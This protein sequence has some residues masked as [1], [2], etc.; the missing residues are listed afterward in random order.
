MQACRVKRS[1]AGMVPDASVR[2]SYAS[3]SILFRP[4]KSFTL[5]AEGIVVGRPGHDEVLAYHDIDFVH[6]YQVHA[7]PLGMIDRCKLRAGRKTI[8]LQ[9]AHVAGPANLQDRRTEYEPFM[10]D[11]VLRIVCANPAVRITVGMPWQSRAGWLFT[12]FVLVAVALGGVVM[13]LDGAWTGLWLIVTAVSA[14]PLTW[15]MVNKKT[16]TPH[17]R[18]DDHQDEQLP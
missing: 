9:S 3:R 12:L 11:L 15:S 2:S 17:R 8:R 18:G 6:L 4:E 13:A 14:A 7:P 5:M 10:R 1:G 16:A